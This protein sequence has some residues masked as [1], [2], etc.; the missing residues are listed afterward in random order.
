[1]FSF[2]SAACTYQLIET[3]SDEKK[4]GLLNRW[5]FFFFLFSHSLYSCLEVALLLIDLLNATHGTI[6]FPPPPFFF[7]R[8]RDR[9]YLGDEVQLYPENFKGEDAQDERIFPAPECCSTA[10]RGLGIIRFGC[11]RV[12]NGWQ[13]VFHE[14]AQ[15]V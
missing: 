7:N 14:I 9:F 2:V 8:N 4:K 5:I 3:N 10:S 6:S 12:Q 13:C 1:V 15:S 11:A